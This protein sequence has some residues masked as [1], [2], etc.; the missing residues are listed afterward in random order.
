ME[1]TEISAVVRSLDEGFAIVEVKQGG[2]GRCHE[3]GG[4]GGQHLTQAFCSAPKTYRVA[5]PV[6]AQ[7]GDS[8]MVGIPAGALRYSANL[9]YGLPILG[10]FAGALLGMQVQG[11]VGAMLG[12]LLGLL[13]AWLIIRAKAHAE[14]G[15]PEFQPQIISP[16]SSNS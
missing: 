12:G 8:V 9:A 1:M 11:D 7:V 16:H 4:C 2:C 14:A 13:L 6:E 5:N 10:I 15:N 3:K